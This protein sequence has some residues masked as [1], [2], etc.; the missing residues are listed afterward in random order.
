MNIGKLGESVTKRFLMKHG[1]AILATNLRIYQGKQ[2][3]EIDILALKNNILYIVEVKSSGHTSGSRWGRDEI[4]TNRKY[5]KLSMIRNI[6][7][8]MKSMRSA[9]GSLFGR[10]YFMSESTSPDIKIDVLSDCLLDQIM[11]VKIILAEVI[12]WQDNTCDIEFHPINAG[13]N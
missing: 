13:Y 11:T 10:E 1:Y 6:I 7:L 9:A 4:L 3:G 5:R 12:I 8:A 2:I